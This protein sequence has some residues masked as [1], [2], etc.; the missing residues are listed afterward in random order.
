MQKKNNNFFEQDEDEYNNFNL[1][2]TFN[3]FNFME[4]ELIYLFDYN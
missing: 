2:S 4:R 1:I 3:K